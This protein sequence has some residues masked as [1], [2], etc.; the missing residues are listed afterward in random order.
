MQKL[1]LST[2]FYKR[3]VDNKYER[4]RACKCDYLPD[5]Y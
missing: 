3:G 4:S 2:L 5:L 1:I